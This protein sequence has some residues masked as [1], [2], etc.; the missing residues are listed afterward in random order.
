MCVCVCV[1]ELGGVKKLLVNKFI[2]YVYANGRGAKKLSTDI[3]IYS[4]CI[5]VIITLFLLYAYRSLAAR[6]IC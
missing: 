2:N 4:K 3:L 6:R 1:Q 5:N